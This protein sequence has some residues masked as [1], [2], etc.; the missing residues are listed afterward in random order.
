MALGRSGCG[1][2]ET[3]VSSRGFKNDQVLIDPRTLR[4]GDD[5]AI[6]QALTQ[7]LKS[8]T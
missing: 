2:Y 4:D 8:G 6:I 3:P 1:S 5:T 7:I